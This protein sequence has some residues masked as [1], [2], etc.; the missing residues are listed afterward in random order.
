MR[1]SPRKQVTYSRRSNHAARAAHARGAREFKTYDTSY[2]RPKQSKKPTVIAAAVA[3]VLLVGLI[4]GVVALAGSCSA[5]QVEL[6][7]DGEQVSITVSEGAGATDVA[8]QLVEVRLISKPKDF[9]SHVDALGVGEQIKSGDYLFEGGMSL[10]EIVSILTTGP[11][12]AAMLTVPEGYMLEDIAKAADK[13]TEG[14][15]SEKD[16]LKVVSDASAY[17]DDY[18]F[19][20]DAGEKSLEGFLFPKTYDVSGDVTADSLVRMMLNQF[21]KETANLDWSYPKSQGLSVYDAVNLASIVEKESSGDE[22]IRAQVAAVFYNRLSTKGEP[23]YGFLQSDATTAYE[24]GGNPT[25]EQVHKDTPYS[26]YTNKGLPPTPICSPGLACLKA[27]CNPD[28]DSLNKYYFFYFEGDK[29]Y[30]TETYD[31]HMDIFS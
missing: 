7:A 30:F 20:K 25:A 18:D 13:A 29:Y 11:N 3:V 5:S 28:Q 15:V 9:T 27:V 16:F 19:L 10:D 8:N 24:V 2:I 21:Q 22:E 4:C 14:V 23:S 17:A 1:M 12:A 31:E 6:L 26:T